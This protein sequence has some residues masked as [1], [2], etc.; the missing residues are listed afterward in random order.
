MFEQQPRSYSRPW[1]ED[2]HT[3]AL[4]FHCAKDPGWPSSRQPHALPDRA[5]VSLSRPH[6]NRINGAPQPF[7]QYDHGVNMNT[8]QQ[9]PPTSWLPKQKLCL[10]GCPLALTTSEESAHQGNDN[11]GRDS[12]RRAASPPWRQA[13]V[14][15][16][17]PSPAPHHRRW[18]PAPPPPRAAPTTGAAVCRSRPPAVRWATRKRGG[19]QGGGG[20]ACGQGACGCAPDGGP[21]RPK[22]RGT[23][24]SPGQPRSGVP[25]PMVCITPRR[26]RRIHPAG[27]GR[28][29]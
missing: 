24:V 27:W 18:P 2:S 9:S 14:K 21:P 20:S 25:P 26:A 13:E 1:S 29:L 10:Q 15:P 12:G 23:R 5:A 17:I 3:V 8:Y 4:V 6:P 28:P 22:E 16:G 7:H 11:D 19:R